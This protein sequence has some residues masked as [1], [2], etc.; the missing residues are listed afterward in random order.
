MFFSV[1]S[2]VPK[3][4]FGNAITMEAPASSDSDGLNHAKRGSCSFP[5]MVFPS[6][7]LGTRG[8]TSLLTRSF[9]LYKNVSMTM[10]KDDISKKIPA[11]HVF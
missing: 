11:K 3:F 10:L 2:L 1:F 6:W 7:S 8:K 9:Q 5:A 4:Q